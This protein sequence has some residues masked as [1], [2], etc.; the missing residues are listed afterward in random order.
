MN[1]SKPSTRHME[2]TSNPSQSQARTRKKNCG[3]QK[4]EE[5][6]DRRKHKV[7]R[8]TK[9]DRPEK[10]RKKRTPLIQPKTLSLGILEFSQFPPTR[11]FT[12]K[13]IERNAINEEMK[14]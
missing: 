3:N 13:T 1:K 6:K 4:N 12:R 8:G 7:R 5:K 11:H 2:V 10:K 9:K 14:K